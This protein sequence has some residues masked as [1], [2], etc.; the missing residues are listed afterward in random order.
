MNESNFSVPV[1]KIGIQVQANGIEISL[2]QS[3]TLLTAAEAQGVAV[4]LL[5]ASESQTPVDTETAPERR[6][7]MQYLQIEAVTDN[8]ETPEEEAEQGIVH[9]WIRDQSPT[10]AVYIAVGWISSEGWDV[11]QIIEN[12]PVTASDFQETDL[13]P[14]YEQAL[15]D[16]EVFVFEVVDADDDGEGE[17]EEGDEPADSEK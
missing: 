5:K 17:G 14:Y 8:S 15:V 4:A 13:L 1:D 11:L 6:L 10:N 3:P 12:K 7:P 9:C 2:P 16:N